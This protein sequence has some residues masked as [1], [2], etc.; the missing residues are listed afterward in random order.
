MSVTDAIAEAYASQPAGEKTIETLEFNHVTFDAPV[1]VATGGLENI[2]LPLVLGG[3]PVTFLATQ[4]SVT[5]PG[6]TADGPTPM[7]IS[8]DNVAS[9]L[10]PYLRAAVGATDPIAVTYRA[11]TSLDLTQP[12]EV[13]GDLE[14][15]DVDLTAASAEG[16]VGFREIELQAFP[17]ATYDE[18]YYPA[19]QND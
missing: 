10:L 6:A 8:V 9:L 12:G 11:Y 2:D 13:I 3:D 1:R 7:K 4:I 15:R 18:Q 17:L 16:S 19:L 5:L 14:L